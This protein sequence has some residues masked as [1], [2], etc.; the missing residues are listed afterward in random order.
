MT[1]SDTPIKCP[2]CG[3]TLST[4]SPKELCPTCLMKQAFASRTV[5]EGEKHASPP[6]SPEE[7]ADKFPQFEI[8]ECL[9]RGGMGVVYKALQ[10]SLKRWVAI[11]ILAPER[12]SEEKF[13]ERFSREAQTL[14]LLNHPNIVTVFDYGEVEGLFYIVMEYVDGLNLRDLLRDGKMEAYQALAIVPPICE[15]LQYAHEKGVVHRDIKPENLLLDREG[16]I[17]IADFGIASLVGVDGEKSGTPPYMA[18]E[19]KEGSVDRRADI[20]ALGVVLFEM[21]TGERPDMDLSAPSSR[22]RG[23]QLDIRIDEMVLRALDKEPEKRYQTAGEFRTAVETIAESNLSQAPPSTKAA[24]PPEIPKKPKSYRWVWALLI[25]ML[26]VIPVVLLLLMIAVYFFSYSKPTSQYGLQRELIELSSSS[27]E[28]RCERTERIV[29]VALADPTKPWA[30]QELDERSV[31]RTQTER[32]VTGL[33]D[34][35]RKTYPQKMTQPLTWMGDF[36][37]GLNKKGLV[38]EKQAVNLYKAIQGEIQLDDLER[39][40]VDEK[41][42]NIRCNWRYVWKDHFFGLVMMNELVEIRID[43]KPIQWDYSQNMSWDLRVFSLDVPLHHLE[44]GLH[45]L[46]MDVRSRFVN[47]ADVLGLSK[48]APSEDWPKAVEEWQRN[49][50]ATFHVHG[51]NEVLVRLNDDK[52]FNPLTKGALSINEM[53]VQSN[54]SSVTLVLPIQADKLTIPICFNV[55]LLLGSQRVDCGTYWDTGN[56]TD[57]GRRSSNDILKVNLESIDPALRSG[58]IILTPL[59]EEIEHVASVKEIWGEELILKDVPMKRLD[60]GVSD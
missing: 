50:S 39:L 20:Y 5:D 37:E 23:V 28:L 13:A 42:L 26:V 29:E 38:D 58:T 49:A 45:T 14:A 60:L 9:G 12:S 59:V 34:W 53:T 31:S 15:A 25:L 44:P 6:P 18:P 24:L 52:K 17:K 22:V 7:I 33:T 4:D 46:E 19:Q 55:T 54:G 16:R 51:A 48:T 35:V 21:L 2:D 36:L 10:K 40:R 8:K 11:K 27:H 47:Q 3:T 57:D 41:N 1:R 43:G 56:L 32:V 30:W